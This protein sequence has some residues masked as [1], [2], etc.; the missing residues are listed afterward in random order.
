MD[1]SN[2]VSS[3]I[4]GGFGLV[5]SGLSYLFNK[6][7]AEQQNQ[8]NIDMWKM[9]NEYNSP[10]AQMQRFK[11]AGLNPN[12]IY[13][14]GTSGNASSAPQMITPSAPDL[15]EDMS[16]LA[17]AFNIE[18]LKKLRAERREAESNADNAHT[19]ERRNAYMLEAER[20][21]GQDWDFDP[22]TGMFVHVSPDV[23]AINRNN[24]FKH[25]PYLKQ[26]LFNY[27]QK[28]YLIP[29]RASLLN[30]QQN[31]LSPQVTY[32]RYAQKYV[33]FSYWIDRVASG[34]RIVPSLINPLK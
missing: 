4:S 34:S 27:Y 1:W 14:Q 15:S 30:T 13:G 3:A 24:D 5:G 12:L 2:P 9:Q 29:Y 32:Q 26:M 22:K 33:P 31:Y 11:D 19:N 7:L 6:K 23:L 8:Y 17:Q 20:H 18:G 21:F 28:G 16:K 25:L 10:Q